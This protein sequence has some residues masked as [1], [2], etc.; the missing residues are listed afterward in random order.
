MIDKADLYTLQKRIKDNTSITQFCACYVDS[1][2]Q[3]LTRIDQRF[4][5]MP[6][7]DYFKW[8]DILKK[9]YVP[10]QIYNK[11][12]YLKASKDFEKD[13]YMDPIIKGKFTDDWLEAFYEKV[14][15][16]F[17]T[18]G[19]YIVILWLDNYDIMNRTSDNQE[20]D[21]SEEVYRYIQCAICPVELDAAGLAFNE[22]TF[23]TKERDWVIE[24]PCM[25]FVYPALRERTAQRDEMIFYTANTKD[26]D[27]YFVENVLGM[28]S[29]RTTDEFKEILKKAIV[30]QME[31]VREQRK[32]LMRISYHCEVYSEPEDILE[33]G[34]LEEL[35]KS[36]GVEAH[37][38]RSIAEYY[39][40]Y[41]EGHYACM[42][43]LGDKKLANE[44]LKIKSHNK[45]IK[46]L[47]GAAN[48]ISKEI[49]ENE[50]TDDINELLVSERLL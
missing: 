4:L 18:P 40:E 30:S 2:K 22:R 41:S 45:K 27:W 1:D 24:K 11:N 43:Q 10:K 12:L 44:Y 33:P 6:E 42:W 9:I 46:L 23:E 48:L 14:I 49:G 26:P 47:D 37:D 34:F 38:A 28:S 3:I 13:F 17:E 8:M 20:L 50:L 7:S 39:H 31:E 16:Y 36:D 25:G 5:N 19:R 29:T 32:I 15:A 21:E 35:L